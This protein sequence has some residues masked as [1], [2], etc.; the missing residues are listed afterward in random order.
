MSDMLTVLP[1]APLNGP[2]DVAQS[3]AV[4]RFAIPA[5]DALPTLLPGR[6]TALAAVRDARE[7]RTGVMFLAPKWSGKTV[8]LQRALAI[9]KQEERAIKKQMPGYRTREAL[10]LHGLKPRTPRDLLLSL[11]RAVSPG[12]AERHIR[13]RKS[14]DHVREDLVTAL[15]NKQYTVIALDEAEY[16]EEPAIDALRKVMADAEARDE[17]RVVETPTGGEEYVA[18]G[19]G[20][21]LAG[22]HAVADTVAQSPD[23]G[24]RWSAP[25]YLPLIPAEQVWRLYGEIF[26]HFAEQIAVMGEGAWADWV[27]FEIAGGREMPVGIVSMHCRRYFTAIFERSLDHGP[28]IRRREFVPFD[29]QL[30]LATYTQLEWGKSVARRT[31][32]QAA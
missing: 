10:Y 15:L 3:L 18:A 22:T 24:L 7:L 4:E 29:Q 32:A 8:A 28:E 30:F 23:D 16:L 1:D 5:L 31:R 27:A 21:V 11:L 19:I 9:M 26:P 2:L 14:D 20:I 6:D 12:I 13:G 17:R 25:Y